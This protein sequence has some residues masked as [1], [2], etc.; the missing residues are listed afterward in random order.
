MITMKMEIEAFSAGTLI[1][2]PMIFLPQIPRA[3]VPI[4]VAQQ[5]TNHDLVRTTADRIQ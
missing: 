3:P 5:K 4:A 2:L 1:L